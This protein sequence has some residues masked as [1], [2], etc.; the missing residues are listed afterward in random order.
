MS[1]LTVAR[2]L[3]RAESLANTQVARA[4]LPVPESGLSCPLIPRPQAKL[5]SPPSG[6]P[7]KGRATVFVLALGLAFATGCTSTQPSAGTAPA[8][9]FN[10]DLT[11]KKAKAASTKLPIY[12]SEADV[13]D[14]IGLSKAQRAKIAAIGDATDDPLAEHQRK[15]MLQQTMTRDQHYRYSELMHARRKALP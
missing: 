9:E 15:W 13:L 10:F 3:F 14:A 8:E 1:I 2:N 7:W 6:T 11:G 4:F 12:N 5:K